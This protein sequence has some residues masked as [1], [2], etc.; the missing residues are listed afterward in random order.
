[1]VHDIAMLTLTVLL[2]GHLYFTFVD[3]ESRMSTKFRV[4]LTTLLFATLVLAGCCGGG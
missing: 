2:V 4:F 1:M 3:Q